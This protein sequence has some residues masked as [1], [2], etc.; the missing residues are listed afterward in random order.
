MDPKKAAETDSSSIISDVL[1]MEIGDNADEMSDGEVQIELKGLHQSSSKPADIEIKYPMAD[2]N[3]S[4]ATPK[5]RSVVV[6]PESTSYR[7]K[8]E[9]HKP[10]T[11][12]AKANK[13]KR[14]LDKN[15]S[16][17]YKT[18]KSEGTLVAL[19]S[20]VRMPSATESSEPTDKQINLNLNQVD[21]PQSIKRVRS[22]GSTPEDG[23]NNPEKLIKMQNVGDRKV[24]AAPSKPN[25]MTRRILN[26]K[27]SVAKRPPSRMDLQTIKKFL[28]YQIERAVEEKADFIPTFNEP[29]RIERDGVYVYCSDQKCADWV[30]W[31]ANGG[32]PDTS[33]AL[34]VLPHETPLNLEPEHIMI[35][36]QTCIPT[37]KPKN[38]ILE[39]LAQLNKELNTEKWNIR[40]L[41][42]KGSSSVMA[43]MKMDKP[44]FDTICARGNQLNWILGPIDIKR[45]EH[46][47]KEK[48]SRA[49]KN[50]TKF[51]DSHLKPRL[52]S[53]V[54]SDRKN[55][56]PNAVENGNPKPK[57][58]RMTGPAEGNYEHKHPHAHPKSKT[59]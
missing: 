30:K 38:K 7:K 44:S 46:G 39:F 34:V 41:R 37:R 27:V 53:T 48:R 31:I 19:L 22:A 43:Y 6:L 58:V 21:T 32:I 3:T 54:D 33:G 42:L 28:H 57:S 13:P 49:A 5:I 40:N 15:S 2:S 24:T 10:S 9:V 47:D 23:K 56:E 17:R 35:R 16:G 52:S 12:H 11:D 14:K 8:S 1:E 55:T 26:I 45:E 20:K 4:L 18:N 51:G 36:V 25:L 59:D 29:C 50:H